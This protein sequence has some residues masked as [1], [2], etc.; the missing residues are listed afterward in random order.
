[1]GCILNHVGLILFISKL[2]IKIWHVSFKNFLRMN[3]GW[4]T[5]IFK[6]GLAKT[7]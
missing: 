5:V 1:M 3:L 4:H 7:N 2:L 6:K